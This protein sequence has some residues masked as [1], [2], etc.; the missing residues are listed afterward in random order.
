MSTS[1]SE[2]LAGMHKQYGK[3]VSFIGLTVNEDESRAQV[4]KLARDFK[5]PFPVFKDEKLT[6]ANALKA[7]VTPECFVL[8]SDFVLRY[9][10]PDRQQLLGTSQEESADDAAGSR[11]GPGRTPVRP[12]HQDGGHAAHRLPDRA[13]Q[14]RSPPRSA[15]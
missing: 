15:K 13:R 11:T 14:P 12:A 9:R 3:H 2:P 7:D 4:A 5:I 1:Y 8:D 6:A 10:G